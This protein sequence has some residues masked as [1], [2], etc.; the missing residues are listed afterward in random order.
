MQKGDQPGTRS[1]SVY[2][3]VQDGQD[4]FD[5]QD[6]NRAITI[7]GQVL[8]E[9]PDDWLSWQRLGHAHLRIG[10]KTEAFES[11]KHAVRIKPDFGSGWGDL[12]WTALSQALDEQVDSALRS[13]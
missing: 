1:K 13:M 3:L 11:L 5:A 8:D 6:W 4:A 2:E 7:F 9:N 10:Q 12:G